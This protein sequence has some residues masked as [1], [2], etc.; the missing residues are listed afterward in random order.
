MN[1]DS[2]D[3]LNEEMLKRCL[4]I[5][6]DSATAMGLHDPYD[7]DMPHGGFKRYK[8]TLDLFLEWHKQA[9]RFAKNEALTLDQ[10]MG[11]KCLKMGI[12]I[13]KFS[14]DD[15][16]M[17]KMSPD[18]LDTP[19]SLF[20]IMGT[21]DY[22]PYEQRAAAISSRISQL[23]RYLEE[24]RARFRGAR[25]VKLWTEIAIETCEE[26][27][28]FMKFI[29]ASSKGR[30]SDK[31][32][33]ELSKN[34]AIADEELKGQLDWLNHLLDRAVVNFPMGKKKFDKL[35]KLRGLGMNSDQILA[36]G[37]K[38]LSEFK[39]ERLKLASKIA[40]GKSV[41][42]AAKIVEADSPK[43]F[44]HALKATVD[45][46]EKAKS[47][48]S[49]NKIAT[50]SPGAVLKVIETPA[51]MAPIIP[52]AALFMPSLF[53]KVQEGAYVVTR[54]KDPKDLGKHLN[55]PSIRGTA[56]HEAFPGHF[57]QGVRSNGKHW[58]LQTHLMVEEPASVTVATE[59]IEGWAHYCEK[60]MFDHGYGATDAAAYTMVNDALWRAW[61]ITV[62]I[63]LARGEITVDEAIKSGIEVVGMSTDGAT[64]EVKRYTRM[65]GQAMSY[66]LGRHLIL[67]FRKEMEKKLGPGFDELRFHDVVAD[68]AYLPF[69]MMKEAVTESMK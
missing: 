53:D 33:S 44:E 3:S 13:L 23:P 5:N 29:S 59:T 32:Y 11:L 17:W 64:A 26:L 24:F 60:M 49:E 69:F 4:V 43:T 28:G 8:D 9:T 47:F 18:G 22:A 45:E 42:E 12:D 30:V 41:E 21:R 1:A 51:F 61:R 54:P 2:F 67:E 14:V 68:Y 66:M 7:M 25:P 55:Y 56:V 39:N 50:V 31:L 35:M 38:Y 63:R 27:P 34:I 48:I 15:Y 20:F 46:M 65:P 57:H 19:G 40:P 36:L 16:P 6:P 52:F 58:M 37:E 10:K 62:D